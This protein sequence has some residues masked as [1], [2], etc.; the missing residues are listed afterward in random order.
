VNRLLQTIPHG[1]RSPGKMA[2]VRKMW[3]IYRADKG[4]Q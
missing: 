2:T 1:Q 4:E 3:R